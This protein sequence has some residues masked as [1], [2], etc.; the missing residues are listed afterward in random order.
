MRKGLLFLG[1]PI[2]LGVVL[3]G[4]LFVPRGE[5]GFQPIRHRYDTYRACN[6]L[7]AHPK[8][9]IKGD[10]TLPLRWWHL[11]GWRST[12]Y[13]A[14]YAENFMWTWYSSLH[15]PKAAIRVMG[16][17]GVGRVRRLAQGESMQLDSS[18]EWVLQSWLQTPV[19][20]A[21]RP[22]GSFTELC[23]EHPERCR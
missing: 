7:I 14:G 19:D 8:G 15:S 21:G 18:G 9:G 16:V 4:P 3:C 23:A 1:V 6:E 5:R 11:F 12:L 22:L 17:C 20:E 10:I 13:D 2:L